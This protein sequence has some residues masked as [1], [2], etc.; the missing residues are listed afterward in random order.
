MKLFSPIIVYVSIVM[1]MILEYHKFTCYCV[2]TTQHTH[3]Q[4]HTHTHTYTLE[5]RSPPL[6]YGSC[7]P[8]NT[9]SCGG[10]RYV[11]STNTVHASTYEQEPIQLLNV[12][13]N[14]K[15]KRSF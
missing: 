14:V 15:V 8:A 12:Y 6:L 4:T 5:T 3:T 13:N 7:A 10:H 11:I 9:F 1:Y 2:S